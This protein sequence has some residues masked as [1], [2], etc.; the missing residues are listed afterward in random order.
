MAARNTKLFSISNPEHRSFI[1]APTELRRG[2]L[3]GGGDRSG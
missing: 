2:G 3:S 1:G